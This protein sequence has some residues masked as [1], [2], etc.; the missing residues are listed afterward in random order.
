MSFELRAPTPADVPAVAQI[1]FDAFCTF[2]DRHGFSRDF[3]SLDVATGF[4]EAWIKHPQVWG[5]VATREDGEIVACNF[6]DERNK[7]PGVGPICVSPAAQGG[8]EGRRLMQAVLDRAKS[9]GA[10]SVRLVQEAYN[11]TSMSLYASLGFEV[12]EPLV[13]MTG[14]PISKPSKG[15]TARPMTE[16]DLPQCAALCERLH[17]FDRTGELRDALAGQ[18]R[19]FVLERGGRVTA[20]ASAPWFWLLNHGV[21]ETDQDMKDLLLGVAAQ[22]DEPIS[23]QVPTRNAALFRW[24]LAEKLRYVKPMTLMAVGEYRDAPAGTWWYPSVEY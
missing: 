12:K 15:A 2:Q 4:M 16:R 18:F 13:V 22:G 21:A 9:Q 19:P 7:V 3:P 8:G 20:Y 10:K 24:C 23:L 17:G 1:V 6:L 14:R 5:V 11:A